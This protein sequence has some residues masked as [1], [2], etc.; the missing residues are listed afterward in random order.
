MAWQ[1]PAWLTMNVWTVTS[2]IAALALSGLGIYLMV[3]ASP[4][5]AST[6]Y[7]ITTPGEADRIGLCLHSVKG[8]GQVPKEGALWLV[9]HGVGNRGYYLSRQ[10]QPDASGNGWA[11]GSLQVGNAASPEGQQ[12]ELILWRLDP[13]VTDVV[14]HVFTAEGMPVFVGPPEGATKVAHTTVVRTAD[15]RPCS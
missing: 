12:Y 3:P 6:G 2:G 4:T 14:D 1:R 11:V 13:K 7:S 9:V 8:A 10:V 15:K 5:Q